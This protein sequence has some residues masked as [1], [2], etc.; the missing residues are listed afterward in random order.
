VADLCCGTGGDLLGIAN[1]CAVTGVDRDSV[2]LLLAEANVAAVCDEATVARS[3]FATSEVAQW[4]VDESDAWHIDPDRRSGGWRTSQP[5]VSSPCSE[6]VSELLAR[7][8]NAAI[9]LAP[10]ARIPESWQ[11]VCELEW[12]G[13][14]GECKQLVAWH[15][16]LAH[17]SRR[18]RATIFRRETSQAVRYI[19]VGSISDVTDDPIDVV[20]EPGRFLYEPESTVRAARLQAALARRH[21]VQALSPAGTLL[22]GDVLLV[23]GL[24]TCFE[25]LDV[26]PLDR[27][28]LACYFSAR[29]I[30]SLEI[31]TR[32]VD[33]SPERLRKQLQLKGDQ[34]A[35]LIVAYVSGVVRAIIVRRCGA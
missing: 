8:A 23:D 32:G 21:N 29:A 30:G 1:R 14:G 31:K 4:P 26:L 9:K 34:S 25:V 35:T 11:D 13:R 19:V 28:Q 20:P 5:E 12:I 22:T 27:R 6:I 10:A 33:V 3:S 16:K 2:A 15:G 18:R 17:G 7:N 24:L